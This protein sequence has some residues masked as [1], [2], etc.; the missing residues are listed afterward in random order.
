MQGEELSFYSPPDAGGVRGGIPLLT[1]TLLFLFPSYL[2]GVRG[3]IPLLTH[4][5]L[6]D[7]PYA[8]GGVKRVS[9]NNIGVKC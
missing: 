3:G 9:L 7:S 5:L 4:T 8:R 1:H 6:P 2:G